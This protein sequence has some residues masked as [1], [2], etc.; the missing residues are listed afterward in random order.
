[1]A[2]PFVPAGI[3][4]TH[5]LGARCRAVNSRQVGTLMTIAMQ[6]G[7][8]KVPER[9]RPTMLPCDDVLDLVWTG[10]ARVRQPTVFA[11]MGGA[12]SYR[13]GEDFIH[14]VSPLEAFA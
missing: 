3:E 5:E 1:M 9:C 11:E 8:C 14:D 6:A 10:M 12:F 4:E 2:L 13:A 7:K